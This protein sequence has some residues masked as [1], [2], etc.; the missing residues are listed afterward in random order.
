M[1]A[2]EYAQRLTHRARNVLASAPGRSTGRDLFDGALAGAA[3]ALGTHPA[4]ICEGASADM[5][6]LDLNDAT[7]VGRK[8][9]TLLD[10]WIFAGGRVD[11][12]GEKDA[13][14]SPA[15]VM[16]GASPS[17]SDTSVP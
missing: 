10:S 17:G 13:N 15:D 3:K 14:G 12:V 4:G 5:L 6:S 1:R 8:G 9:D 11:C 16:S 2:L 7:L